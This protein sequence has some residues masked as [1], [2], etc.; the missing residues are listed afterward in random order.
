MSGLSS[1]PS[2][3]PMSWAASSTV[4]PSGPAG[5]LCIPQ[6]GVPLFSAQHEEQVREDHQS[7]AVL[8]QPVMH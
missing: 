1:S 7:G 8:G 6:V 2:L 4:H 3:L 5:L